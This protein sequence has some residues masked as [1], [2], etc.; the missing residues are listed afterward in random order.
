MSNPAC[1]NC[2]HFEPTRNPAT[3]RVL[4]SQPGRCGYVVPWPTLPQCYPRFWQ[5]TPTAV[6]VEGSARKC[7]CYEA[8]PVAARKRQQ[9]ILGGEL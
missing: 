7:A 4:P 3:G 2:R 9:D 5:P 1:G 8:K 6:W